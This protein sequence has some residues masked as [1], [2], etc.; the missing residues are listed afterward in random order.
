MDC[1]TCSCMYIHTYGRLLG[2]AQPQHASGES[3]KC[4]GYS[5]S[6][7]AILVSWYGNARFLLLCHFL[8]EC[9]QC[10]NT[11]PSADRRQLS[12]GLRSKV[13]DGARCRKP[14]TLA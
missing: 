14:I 11:L 3:A 8:G 4:E 10:L 6:R 13:I 5:G 1:G 9:R 12:S 2:I 7:R